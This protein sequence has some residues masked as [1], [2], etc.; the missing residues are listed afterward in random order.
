MV[1]CTLAMRATKKGFSPTIDMLSCGMED[2]H[3]GPC[4]PAPKILPFSRPMS[5][6]PHLD[7]ERRLRSMRDEVERLY[8]AMDHLTPEY[9]G[10]ME[11]LESKIDDLLIRMEKLTYEF[12]S[13]L[14]VRDG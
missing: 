1:P 2:G 3:V 4:R 6:H 7:A 10:P 9:G 5:P 13:L 11:I 14:E 8:A 12:P